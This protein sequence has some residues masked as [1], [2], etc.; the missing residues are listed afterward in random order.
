MQE[1]FVFTTNIFFFC[2]N[3]SIIGLFAKREEVF[4]L[5]FHYVFTTFDSNLEREVLVT[6]KC[7]LFVI[8]SRSMTCMQFHK[9]ASI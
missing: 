9:R 7:Q 8:Y 6:K 5:F 2:P 1:V 3:Q 4:C